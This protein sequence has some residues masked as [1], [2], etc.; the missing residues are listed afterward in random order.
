MG[1]VEIKTI[2]LTTEYDEEAS[3]L[4]VAAGLM[5]QARKQRRLAHKLHRDSRRTGLS[6][7][8]GVEE[9]L[10]MKE[11]SLERGPDALVVKL[12]SESV[13]LNLTAEEWAG[14]MDAVGGLCAVLNRTA[15]EAARR[16]RRILDTRTLNE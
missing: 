15:E 7:S 14:L 9:T 16:A 12:G 2:P 8:L 10:K 4:A 11:G 6:L 3:A 1:Q 5:E 13:S